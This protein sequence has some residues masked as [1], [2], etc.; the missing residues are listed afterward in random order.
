MLL[1]VLKGF[2]DPKD[3]VIPFRVTGW[4]LWWFGMEL[5]FPEGFQALMVPR[6][7]Y[8][9]GLVDGVGGPGGISEPDGPTIPLRVS[10]WCLWWWMVLVVL[11]GFPDPKDPMIPFRV[12]GWCLWWW[13]ELVVLTEF[14]ALMVP[15]SHYGHGVVDGVGGP[16][17]NS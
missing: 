17:G 8:G 1:V 5:V 9:R 2:P 11:K 10:G 13:M 6:S 4:C 3:P 12:S 15:Q 16:G 7:H 14:Q